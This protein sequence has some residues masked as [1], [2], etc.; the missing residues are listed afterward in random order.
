MKKGEL[1]DQTFSYLDATRK[2][3]D[4]N[5]IL[6]VKDEEF[7]NSSLLSILYYDNGKIYDINTYE[8]G[9]KI[10]ATKNSQMLEVPPLGERFSLLQLVKISTGNIIKNDK[11][12]EGSS[13]PKCLT[14]HT[15]I[16]PLKENEIIE[17]FEGHVNEEFA[18]L[19]LKESFLNSL[20]IEYYINTDNVFFIH[21]GE[22]LKGPFKIKNTDSSGR[23][24]IEKNLNSHWKTF[25]VY[26]FNNNSYVEFEA[27]EINR[28]IIIPNVNELTL[29]EKKDFLTNAELISKFEIQIT[30]NSE[31]FSEEYLNKF[32]EITKK[33]A[34]GVVFEN[35]DYQKRLENILKRNENGILSNLNITKLL[36][37]LSI[38]RQEIDDL[39]KSKFS[40]NNQIIKINDQIEAKNVEKEDIDKDLSKLKDEIGNL[41][42]HKEEELKHK[43]SEIE[44]EINLLEEK[45]LSL[46]QEIETELDKKS[47][48]IKEKEANIK[49]LEQREE[50]LNAGI[51]TLQEQFTG[52][53]KSAHQ[54]LQDLLCQNQHYNILSGR[55]INYNTE[56]NPLPYIDYQVNKSFDKENFDK[57]KRYE[58]IK[59]EIVEILGCNNRKFDSHFIDNILISVH[60]NTLTLFAGLPGTGKTTLVRLLM[61]ILSP[62]TRNREI[63]VSRGWTSQKDLIGFFNPLSRNFHSSVTN[64]Y[65]L[66][67]QL[68]WER[69]ENKYLDSPLSYILLDE[70]NLSPLEHYWSVFYNLTDSYAC[71]DCGLKI[72][73]G[74]TENIEYSNNLRFIGTINYDQ[75]TEELSP[76]VIDRANIIRMDN[77]KSIDITV[78][79]NSNIRNIEFN[80]RE[81]IEIFELIDFSKEQNNIA[82]DE[83]FELKFNSIKDKFKELKIFISP[84][85][86]IAIKQYCKVAKS[87][88]YEQ[89]KPLDYCIAQRL[90]PL[91][92]AQGSNAKQKLKELKSMLDDNKY[93]ISSKILAEIIQ[94]GE[95]GEVFQ[96][97]FNYFLTLSHV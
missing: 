20:F 79:N 58:D 22:V 61:N 27:N 24:I 9:S 50:S 73:L 66:L 67:K 76:R 1:S 54:K 97:N 53:Q 91:I 19:E 12:Y 88:M 85:V 87:V 57:L 78:L 6:V 56:N 31:L 71:E 18:V 96:D 82:L 93:D 90:L 3:N 29:I 35:L 34:A 23:I 74:D 32:I 28:K 52:E 44:V 65:G 70:A 5:F 55:E 72:N 59:K 86:Q 17:I 42:K 8:M 14:F 4:N 11:Y 64:L 80:F 26:E 94:T 13:F 62:Q 46:D 21:E 75:T 47:T 84:R 16:H 38:V 39:E 83:E 51:K 43:K 68:D 40:L 10:L 45:K 25:G 30:K 69:R 48:K 2:F 95:E 60:Q 33:V 36:P 81:C 7:P 89:N 49:Y 92:K 15:N 77:S 37:E 41:E 63:S